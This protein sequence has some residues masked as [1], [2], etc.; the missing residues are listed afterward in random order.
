M[1]AERYEVVIVSAKTGRRTT[2]EWSPAELLKGATWLKR[3]NAQGGDIYLRPLDGSAL[4]LVDGLNIAALEEMR[5]RGLVPA[6]TV[7]TSPGRFQAW[8]KLSDHPLPE[9][10]RK[11]A[12]SGLARILLKVG[13]YGRLVGFTNQQVDPNKAGRQPFVLTHDATGK[14]APAA[15]SYLADIERHLR[16]LAAE[17]QR[18]IDAEKA[19]KAPRHD[20]GRSR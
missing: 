13:P 18:L 10:L 7:E 8:V 6:M 16:E 15:Q 1:G 19:Q 12:V 17:K 2:R 11:H 4:L 9:E 5:K 20:R 3:M 14:V